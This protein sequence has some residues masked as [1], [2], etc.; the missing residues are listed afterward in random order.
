ME[1]IAIIGMGSSGMAV[2]AAYAKEVDKERVT[3]DCYD[4]EES[5]GRGYPYRDDSHDLILNLKT[6]KI[7]YDYQ[8]ND[9]LANW[10]K[11]KGKEEPVYTSRATF[12]EYTRDRLDESMSKIGAQKITE[13]IVRMDKVGKQWELE[14]EKGS[15]NRYDRVHLCNGEIPQRSIYNKVETHPN[16]IQ[17]IYP[18]R[19]KLA[20]IKEQDRVCVIGAGLTG[21]DV[22]THLITEKNIKKVAMFSRTNLIPTVRVEPVMLEMKVFTMEALNG[23]L[24]ENYGRITFE[25]FDELFN[26]ELEVHDID[27]ERFV[28]KHMQGGI[29]E[30]KTNIREP[31]ELARVQAL[32]PIMNVIFNKVWDSMPKS[33]RIKFRRKYHPFMTL[34]RS[35]LPLESARILI[36]A[37][38]KG[39]LTM[40]TQIEDIIICSDKFRLK[41]SDGNIDDAVGEFD[42]IINATG[43]DTSMEKVEEKNELL[44]QLMDKRYVL[45]DEYGGFAVV[46]E[47]MASISSR[48]GTLENLHIHGVL[49]SGVQYRNNSTL[50]MQMTAH[51]LIKELY[52]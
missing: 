34:N 22:T 39:I 24:E 8:N 10:L 29:E 52:C 15:I 4:T 12:G 20:H 27:F 13:K 42:Y 46:P 2:L 7:S 5:F 21:V 3:I 40:P 37:S 28:Q 25:Q 17:D 36:D 19:E 30:L 43:L 35:P 49:A 51:R 47:T 33:D 11:E 48:Y 16:Y 23:I 45:V 44:A 41:K 14:T 9:D 26:K 31:D 18:I 38:E 6:R 50:I 32:L 1:K